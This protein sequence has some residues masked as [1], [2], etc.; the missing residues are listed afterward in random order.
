M[1]TKRTRQKHVR[2]MIPILEQEY[3]D[4][5]PRLNFSTPFELLIASILAAQCTDER[6]NEVTETLF[7]KYK[8]PQDY[9]DSDKDTLIEEI[10][11]TGAYSRK[12]NRIKLCCK[13]LIE[14]FDSKVPDNMDDL[15][16]LPGV[17]RKTANMLL[18]N[19]YDKPGIIMDTHLVRVSER[20]GLTDKKTPDKMEEDLMEVVAKKNWS[21]FS[22]LIMFHGQSVC[23]SRKP[24]CEKCKISR[25]CDYYR[26]KLWWSQIHGGYH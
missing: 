10:F 11:S 2:E 22:H 13:T 1:Y 12:A 4:A 18:V 8:T 23:V 7:D 21:A 14:K 9:I 5:G 3:P 26:K 17:G 15:I 20:L 16:S 24:R 6:V 19:C 25:Y